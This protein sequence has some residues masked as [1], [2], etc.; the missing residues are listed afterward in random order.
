MRDVMELDDFA[1]FSATHVKAKVLEDNAANV[2]HG[3]DRVS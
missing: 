1:T 2:R 3:G